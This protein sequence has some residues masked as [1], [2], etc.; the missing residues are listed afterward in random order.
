MAAVCSMLEENGL[1]VYAEA[2]EHQ[3]YDSL[4][5][6]LD[7]SAADFAELCDDVGMTKKGHVKRLRNA[8]IT[9]QVVAV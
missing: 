8:L 3:G 4:P 1:S 5:H 2:F 6:L 9:A 7:L